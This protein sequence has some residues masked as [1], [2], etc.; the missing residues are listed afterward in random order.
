MHEDR[1]FYC[2]VRRKNG[3]FQISGLVGSGKSYTKWV[4]VL[5]FDPFRP[6]SGQDRSIQTRIGQFR[7]GQVN[8]DPGRLIKTRVGLFVTKLVRSYQDR[9]VWYRSVGHFSDSTIQF[10]WQHFP[11]EILVLRRIS[12]FFWLQKYFSFCNRASESVFRI[13]LVIV[14]VRFE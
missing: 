13:S 8:L 6:S 5:W 10:F 14:T 9:C 4:R 12:I 1:W 3:K 2:D 7:L 11:W